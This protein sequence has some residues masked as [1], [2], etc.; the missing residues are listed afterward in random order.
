VSALEG[1]WLKLDRAEQTIE[2]VYEAIVAYIDEENYT[3]VGQ[4]YADTSEYVLRGKV[5]KPTGE[6]GVIAGDVVH[7]LRS[8]LD[9]LA[10]QLALLNTAT[11][12]DRTQFPIAISPGEF[13]SKMGQKMI[14][15]LSSE[16]RAR[17]ESFQPY[18]GT[19]KAW[20]PL[21]L[22]DLR[23][24]S[25]TDKHRVI[26]A[27][28]AKTITK[29]ELM[30]VDERLVIVRDATAYRDVRWFQ[31]GPVEG[32]EIARMTL[33]GVGPDPEVK[34]EGLL[35]VTISFDDPALTIRH[36]HVV[37]LLKAI[38]KSVREVVA[39]FEADL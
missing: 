1:V 10:W 38:L 23:V 21:A 35:G 34:V 16:H 28:A 14:G 32:A 7:N 39:A 6:I 20:T 8:A 11:P 22:R 9:H 15:D 33:E 24:L 5:T 25:N 29:R 2:E 27:T 36:A 37:P 30:M 17:I 19:N 4:F 3:V 13:G 18:H 26:N 31:G 12:N